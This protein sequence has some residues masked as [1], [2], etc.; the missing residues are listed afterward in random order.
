MWQRSC[1]LLIS[2][3]RELGLSYAYKHS[4][5]ALV[6][7]HCYLKCIKILHDVSVLKGKLLFIQ[8]NTGK[9]ENEANTHLAKQRSTLKDQRK[10]DIHEYVKLLHSV[11]EKRAEEL[12]D[13]R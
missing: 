1:I 13:I 5:Y 8:N 3:K 12:P 4:Q 9:E 2:Y 11:C 6:E 7:F 10:E